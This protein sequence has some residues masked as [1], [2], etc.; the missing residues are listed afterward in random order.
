MVPSAYTDGI[1]SPAGWLRFNPRKISN[2]VFAQDSP[3]FDPIG[4]S[5]FA[6]SLASLL[7][8]T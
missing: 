5:D 4:L 1:S 2:T 6:G 3:I 8:M 7:I